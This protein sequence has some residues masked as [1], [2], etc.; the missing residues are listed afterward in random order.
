MAITIEPYRVSME[1][2]FNDR[3]DIDP[4]AGEGSILITTIPTSEDLE[5]IAV[6]VSYEDLGL[7]IQS[8][9]AFHAT[10]SFIVGE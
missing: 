9:K 5:P 7:L 2:R 10:G 6:E 3:L 4:G 8:L 1:D